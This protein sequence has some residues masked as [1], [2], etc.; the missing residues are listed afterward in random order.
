MLAPTVLYR[1]TIALVA[2]SGISSVCFK[3]KFTI[4]VHNIIIESTSVTTIAVSIVMV[5]VIILVIIFTAVL[6]SFCLSW[7][8]KK[9]YKLNRIYIVYTCTQVFPITLLQE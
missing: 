9:R 2:A 8:K 3:L 5:M 7:K 1:S 4:L 6:T